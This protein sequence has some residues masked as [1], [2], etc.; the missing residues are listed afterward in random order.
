MQHSQQGRKQSKQLILN[1]L[2]LLFLYLPNANGEEAEIAVFRFTDI[3][4]EISLRHSEDNIEQTT[5][6]ILG[7]QS[8]LKSSEEG[9]SFLTHSYVYHPKLLNIELGAGLLY[10]QK[11]LQGP[12]GIT[13]TEGELYN[14][15]ARLSFLEGKPY[16]FS[17][18][19]IKSN[20]S[21]TVFGTER[22]DVE[23][24]KYGV[25]A[26][27]RKPVLPFVVSLEAY[28][29]TSE[30]SS[31]SQTIDQTND[32][33]S[34]R[35]FRDLENR[36]SVQF[37]YLG[38]QYVSESGIRERPIEKVDRTS[39][40]T[41]F[42]SNMNFGEK[43]EVKFN[44]IFS[45]FTQDVLPQQREF[46]WTPNLTWRHSDDVE[47]YYHFDYLESEINNID[48]LSRAGGM[49]VTVNITDKLD[50]SG[51]VHGS[52]SETVD[53]KSN[54]QGVSS[55][56][57]YIQPLSVGRLN[58]GFGAAYDLADNVAPKDI[59][60]QQNE[61]IRYVGIE[62]LQLS[63]FFVNEI[64]N[65]AV[66]RNGVIVYTTI[67]GNGVDYQRVDDADGALTF[68]DIIIKSTGEQKV[69]LGDTLIIDYTYQTGGTVSISTTRYDY[70]AELTIFKYYSVYASYY[71]TEPQLEE[72]Y[73]SIPLNPIKYTRYGARVDHPFMQ[74]E[75]R[76]GLETVHEKQEE[77]L[78]PYD[79][80]TTDSFVDYKI[81]NKTK[82]RL[83]LRK[84][85][86]DNFKSNEDIDL[87]AYSLSLT[88]IPWS[89][90]HFRLVYSNDK[91]VG[92]SLERRI[93]QSRVQFQWQLRK[94]SI[95]LDGSSVNESQGNISREVNS[96][97]A[98]LKR[99]F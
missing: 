11:E 80:T 87:T 83:G 50:V 68:I 98:N 39:E 31:V 90:A 5:A 73:S 21:T 69:L 63:R 16:P 7:Y 95:F 51:E 70:S 59:V 12:S 54:S 20:P 19:Y 64:L 35:A 55:N 89:R 34:L 71:E 36:G 17:L 86:Q 88:T 6:G 81:T 24:I 13:E 93:E 58:L 94:L 44:N 29:E 40:T 1:A 60:T 28:R 33:V 62:R 75:L 85:Q 91:D 47:S 72:G 9:I 45:Y 3:E 76:L 84:I 99:T 66:E 43:Q 41:S 92:G 26:S 22:S 48:T 27:I 37:D 49:G 56:V 52:S 97:S 65:I 57:R 74:D 23:N 8:R 61:R 78:F 96:V 4:G 38:S 67:E 82:V 18:Y 15:S 46:R 42:A 53:F 2:F 32:Q 25:N 77:E 30:G 79:R 10:T 14:F